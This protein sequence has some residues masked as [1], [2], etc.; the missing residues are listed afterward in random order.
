MCADLLPLAQSA[1]MVA[2]LA[3]RGSS[4]WSDESHEE[5]AGEQHGNN[6]VSL[7]FSRGI[8]FRMESDFWKSDRHCFLIVSPAVRTAALK[9]VSW[10]A[11]PR[12]VA[13]EASRWRWQP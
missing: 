3:Q 12:H 7:C 1:S 5:G 2:R 4:P 6:M 9:S 11:Q 13:A 8:G 10:T